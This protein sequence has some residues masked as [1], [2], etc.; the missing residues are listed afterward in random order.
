MGIFTY[1]DPQTKRVYNFEYPGEAPTEQSFADMRAYVE[2]ERAGYAE[3]YRTVFGEDIEYDDGT[4]LGRGWTSGVEDARGGIGELLETLGQRTGWEGLA[5]YGSGMQQNAIENLGMAS[6]GAPDPTSWRDVQGLGSGLTYLGELAGASAPI[7]GVGAAGALAATATAPVSVPGLVAGGIGATLATTPYYMGSIMQGQERVSG[8][9]NVNLGTAALGGTVAA[10]LDSASLLLLGR[11]GIGKAALGAM[12]GEVGRG[13]T[14]RILTGAGA[15]AAT[16]SVTEALQETTQMLAEGV[17]PASPEVQER[18]LAAFIGGGVLGGTIGG[19][20]RGLFGKRPG[21]VTPPPAPATTPAVPT[22]LLGLP[23][24]EPTLG[25]PGPAVLGRL[26]EPTDAERTRA[27]PVPGRGA[28]RPAAEAPRTLTTPVQPGQLRPDGRNIPSLSP[29][30]QAVANG[31][32]REPQLLAA[33]RAIEDAGKATVE[34]IQ[35]A[36]G[37]SYPAARGLMVKLEGMGAV[38]K[39]APNKPRTLTL[40]FRVSAVSDAANLASETTVDPR[41]AAQEKLTAARAEAAAKQSAAEAQAAAAAA[42]TDAA[43]AAAQT[44][45][46]TDIGIDETLLT[47]KERAAQDKAAKAAAKAADAKAKADA[48]AADAKAEAMKAALNAAQAGAAAEVQETRDNAE[49]VVQEETAG[50]APA[51]EAEPE[52]APELAPEAAPVQGEAPNLRAPLVPQ[53]TLQVP[54]GPTLI[55]SGQLIPSPGIR[56]APGRQL[57]TQAA[58]QRESVAR[59]MS[60]KNK[61]ETD[62][63]RIR[64][65]L[66]STD[67]LPQSLREEAKALGIKAADHKKNLQRELRRLQMQHYQISNYL[68]S[69]AGLAQATAEG[70]SNQ[71][72][73]LRSA[74][75]VAARTAYREWYVGNTPANIQAYDADIR[76]EGLKVAPVI[77]PET[78]V[79]AAMDPRVRERVMAE[80]AAAAE[81]SDPTTVQDKA[82]LLNLL[83]SGLRRLPGKANENA[84]AAHAYFSKSRDIADALDNIAADAA[85]PDVPGKR[86]SSKQ[87]SLHPYWKGTGR[88]AAMKA[89]QWVEDNLSNDAL[90]YMD[91]KIGYFAEDTANAAGSVLDRQIKNTRANA[92]ADSKTLGEY[93]KAMSAAEAAETSAELGVESGVF[94]RESLRRMPSRAFSADLDTINEIGIDIG[95]GM[96]FNKAR[97]IA[98]GLEAPLHPSVTKALRNGN[99]KRALEALA[100]TAVDPSVSELAGRLANFVGDTKVL[101]TDMANRDMAA[102][103]RRLLTDPKTGEVYSG[104]YVLMDNADFDRLMTSDP[105]YAP[106][107]QNAVL[108]DAESGMNAHTILHEVLHPATYRELMNNPNGP[109]ARRLEELRAL[110]E[111]AIGKD[112]QYRGEQMP[113]G[114]TNVREFV[115]EALTNQEFQATLDRIYPTT[116]KVTALEQLMRTFANFIRTRIM[117]R[118]AKVYNDTTFVP[119]RMAGDSLSVLD[120]VDRMTRSILNTAPEFGIYDALYDTAKRPAAAQEVINSIGMRLKVFG[121]MDALKT[122][123]AVQKAAAAGGRLKNT[124]MPV[125]LNLFTPN[126]NLVDL[127]AKYFPDAMRVYENLTKNSAY[128]QSLRV[129]L[130][131]TLKRAYTWLD[132][133]PTLEQRFHSMRTR[134]SKYEI[135]PRMPEKAYT[136]FVVRYYKYSP[137]GGIGDAKYE[138]FNSASDARDFITKVNDA[139][140]KGAATT[141]ARILFTPSDEN[142]N[143][144]RSLRKELDALEASAPGAKKAYTDYLNVAER[145]HKEAGNA[146]KQRIEA[147]YPGRENAFTRNTMLR[148]Q[149]NKIFAERGLLAYQPLQRKGDFRITY[150]GVHP[151]TNTVEPFV[152]YFGT[153]QQAQDAAARLRALPP[154]YKIADVEVG[155][156]GIVDSYGKQKVPATFV[157]DVVNTLRA[158]AIKDAEAARRRTLAD[159]K[160]AVE[161][162]AEHARVLATLTANAETNGQKIVEMALNTLPESSIFSAYRARTGVSGFIGDLSPLKTAYDALENDFDAPDVSRGLFENFMD[163]MMQR[164]AGIHQQADADLVRAYLRER[165]T[166][167]GAMVTNGQ[168]TEAEFNSAN[169]YYDTMMTSLNSPMI[170]RWAV[171]NAANTGAYA[172]TLLGN[173]S[174]AF[175][176]LTGAVIFVY[177]RLAAKYGPTVAAKMMLKSLRT[178]AN[179]GRTRMEPVVG[180]NGETNFVPVD[181]G[182]F[183][184]SI[185]NYEFT[186]VDHSQGFNKGANKTNALEYLVREGTKRHVLIDSLIYD[187]LDMTKTPSEA[188]NKVLHWGS[189]PMHH[190]E[191]LVRESAV[192]TTYD[193]ELR[194]IATEKGSDVLT[195]AEMEQAARTAVQESEL[196]TGTIPA[197]AAPNWA[198]R[199]IMPSIAMYKR[200]PLAM[201]H[202]IV[203]DIAHGLPSKA[204][205]T[206]MHGA[207]TPALKAALENRKV[208]RLQT[209]GVLGGM[210]LLSGAMGLPFYGMIAD[211]WDLFLTDPDEE[212][213][214]TLVRMGI[215]ELGSKGILNYLTGMEFSSRI[216]LGDALYRSPLQAENQPPLWNLIESFGG[217]AVSLLHNVTTRA[218]SLYDE[219]E[220]YRALEAAAPAAL[221]NIMRSGR[222]LAEGSA[223]SLRDDIIAD[224]APG[225]ALAQALGFAPASYIRQVEL[226]SVAKRIDTGIAARKSAILRRMNLA[227]RNGDGDAYRAAMEQRDEFNRDHPSEQI[228]ADTIKR[229]AKTFERTTKRVING[230]IFSDPQNYSLQNVMRLMEEPATIW[231]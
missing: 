216:G 161:A 114:L 61:L 217:P 31:L 15:G 11:L 38:S 80:E 204:K 46:A 75:N 126:R 115:S 62:M 172:F 189:L 143:L 36:L 25:L 231:D 167:L 120:E 101:T 156:R 159:G 175:L 166:E 209:A 102:Y 182:L 118:P 180:E 76:G 84:R 223:S 215:T 207:D 142:A 66:G 33:A 94:S 137:D 89:A 32:G 149:Y 171:T 116:K 218:K 128:Q 71:E 188:L 91:E 176:N 151:E 64:A 60:V 174:S 111:D 51:P 139:E 79:A 47:A 77:M 1:T 68:R 104:T 134:A 160:S 105:D 198:Q 196:M 9:D 177:P 87:E 163:S 187:Y 16:E 205:L 55:G 148:A 37:L 230:V 197:T 169:I 63:G 179:S 227:R 146:L 164:V 24:P 210:A 127:A 133:H 181:V 152:H 136:S 28:P 158:S 153:L 59:Q 119:P 150:S 214:D 129:E 67:K 18:L 50:A 12:S 29:D 3:K 212:D 168:M 132:A 121:P 30:A 112:A 26:P 170:Q 6:I 157:T 73:M 201:L 86:V 21:D 138:Y 40:P 70:V 83:K 44:A 145:L 20:G 78:G 123:V 100:V 43:E 183:G 39:F 154:E 194:R 5:N 54:G 97:S 144:Y 23:A 52:A 17:D 98:F 74:E 193:L 131:N 165:M 178:I 34:V 206:E 106:A 99:L 69:E 58:A 10:A 4:A 213:F 49:A 19:A 155:P 162:E 184:R 192:I 191:R 90:S 57:E 124:V 173:L 22:P 147:L 96:M 229:S 48:K 82:K 208:A 107:I 122:D 195:Q 88:E 95:R 117:G 13:L 65:R 42:K 199:G 221:R 27:L 140:A 72:A 35:K 125:M 110:V 228:T 220:Y 2:Q 108:L 222:F 185:R 93:Y 224:I 7:M 81:A 109:T 190:I 103:V 85:L 113:Y 14:G 203:R 130:W 56:P 141:K 202:L 92:E 211:L 219:G 8:E 226:N 200:Y 45:D 53:A 225:E 186:G 41:V 135:D